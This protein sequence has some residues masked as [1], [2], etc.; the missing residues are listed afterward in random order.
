MTDSKEKA[1]LV[2]VEGGNIISKIKMNRA[3]QLYKT[4]QAGRIFILLNSNQG[5][6][7]VF[8]IGNYN[9]IISISLDSLGIPA[10]DYFI[11]NIIVRGPYSRNVALELVK[12]I[13]DMNISSILIVNDNFHIRRSYLVY[14]KV[15]QEVNIKVYTNSFDIYVD[16]ETWWRSIDGVRRVTG[17]YIKLVYYW[18]KGY[19]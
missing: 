10:N 1:D 7:D 9:K 4:G 12:L 17:E 2:V 18:F 13:K 14:Q 15:L 6:V 19:I 11:H 3:I 16:T 8:G 5:N